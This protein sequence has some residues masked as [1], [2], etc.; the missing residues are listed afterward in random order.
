M[1]SL[2][3]LSRALR[4]MGIKMIPVYSPEARRRSERAFG[5]HQGR[6]PFELA[7]ANITGMEEANRYL[8]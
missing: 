7:A 4:H 1:C 6:L 2:R 8:T 5:T 3:K